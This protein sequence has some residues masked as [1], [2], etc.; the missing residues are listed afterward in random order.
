MWA[1]KIH[2]WLLIEVVDIISARLGVLMI[3]IQRDGNM[4]QDWK[5]ANVLSDIQEGSA[6]SGRKLSANQSNIN[7]V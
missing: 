4:P 5:K 1:S 7:C 2:P 6:K 3:K